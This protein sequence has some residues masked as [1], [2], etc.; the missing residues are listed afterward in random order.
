MKLFISV[1]SHLHQNV[2]I[3]LESIKQIANKEDVTLV[4]LDNIATPKL[5]QYCRKYGIHYLTNKSAQ[6]F[7]ANNNRVFQHC[8]N[9][10]GMTD[11]DAFMLLN[12][13]V[14]ISCD[15]IDKLMTSV[16]KKPKDIHAPNLFLDK[17]HLVHDDNI[18]KYPKF[19]NFVRTYLFNDRSTMI[20][21]RTEKMPH[22]DKIWASGAAMV[23]KASIYK[24]LGGFDENY[25][26]Y[27]EDI[28]LCMRAKKAGYLVN[29][30]DQAEAVHFRQRE[31]KRFLTCYFFW[32]V[33][34]VFLYTLA[35][36]GIRKP[37]TS[38]EG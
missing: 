14:M 8:Q 11:E 1:V 38:L 6:G 24:S 19:W 26:L 23:M 33:E 37:K 27:C 32:H 36:Y 35:M 10:L 28:D 13:D 2:I 20:D 21:R 25:Y 5:R 18:R 3:N 31:S 22:G 17:E 29:Y 12:P 9:Q 30:N 15:C 34:S 7:A 4:C 16:Q